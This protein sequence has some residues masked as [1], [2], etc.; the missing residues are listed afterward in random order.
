MKNFKN[1]LLFIL[2]LFLIS[3][4]QSEKTTNASIIESLSNIEGKYIL[5][6]QT[7]S[8]S[9]NAKAKIEDIINES[10]QEELINALVENMDNEKKS[11]STL[12]G[13]VLPIGIICYEALT[14]IIYFEP[15]NNEGDISS[16]WK[17]HLNPQ[18]TSIQMREAKKAWK[19]VVE[20]KSFIYQ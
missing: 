9:F 14:Q 6:P 13:K 5:N 8:Y 19:K 7:K 16:T 15:T 17:G 18:A 3:G 11:K 12:N 20:M 2:A 1:A 4:C 10:N